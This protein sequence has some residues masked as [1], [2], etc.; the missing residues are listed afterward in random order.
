M[1]VGVTKYADVKVSISQEK[2]LKRIEFG[3]GCQIV[4]SSTGRYLLLSLKKH[5]KN[6]NIELI[7]H[8]PEIS[9]TL[10]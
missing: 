1:T 2:P 7:V 4:T 8:F 9:W 10:P 5:F 3:S 6:Q